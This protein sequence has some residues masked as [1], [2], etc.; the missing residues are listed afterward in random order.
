MFYQ[1]TCYPCN[2]VSSVTAETAQS[3]ETLKEFDGDLLCKPQQATHTG[4]LFQ[5]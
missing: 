3:P 4:T 1:T 2:S 5:R